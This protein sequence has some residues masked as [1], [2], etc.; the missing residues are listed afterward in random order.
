MFIKGKIPQTIA[1]DIEIKIQYYIENLW[2]SSQYKY[3]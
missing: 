3:A 1:Y 2:K